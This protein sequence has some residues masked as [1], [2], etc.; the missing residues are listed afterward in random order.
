MAAH[1]E[2]RG[3]RQPVET[4]RDESSVVP[5]DELLDLLGDEYTRRVLEVVAEQPRC[6]RA[7]AEAADVSRPTAYRRLND[8]EAAGL[9]RTEL[10]VSESG[11]HRQRYEA[12]AESVAVS[13]EP[14]RIE[15]TVTVAEPS[16]RDHR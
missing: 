8:L 16:R 3:A 15:A 11:H 12:V 1:S 2:A 13:L 6:G 14:E 9:V 10:V 5:T 4:D 7:V